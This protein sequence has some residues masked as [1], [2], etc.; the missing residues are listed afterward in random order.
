M[1]VSLPIHCWPPA[2][3]LFRSQ[4]PVIETTGGLLTAVIAVSMHEMHDVDSG[5]VVTSLD[6]I[7]HKV[8]SRVRSGDP[9]ALLAHLHAVL[10]DEMGFVGNT[11]DYYNPRNSYLPVVLQQ[12]RGLPITLTLIYKCVAER[13]GLSVHGVNAPWHFIAEVEVGGKTMLVD[14]FFGGRTLKREEAFETMER[15]SGAHIPPDDRLLARATHCR[16]VFRVLQ[17]LL[18]VFSRSERRADM[19]AMYELQSLLR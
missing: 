9:N 11:T 3:A 13:V 1:A 18:H 19:A 16:W 10:F 8:R 5:Q 4:L 2:Y 6:R 17:N 15:I 12:C 7:A 14:P